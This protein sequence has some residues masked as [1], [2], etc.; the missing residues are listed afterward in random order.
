[1]VFFWQFPINFV[2]LQLVSKPKAFMKEHYE[3]QTDLRLQEEIKAR[4]IVEAKLRT[5]MNLN[6]EVRTP[7]SLIISSLVS[8]LKEDEDPHRRS[9][10]ETMRRNTERLLKLVH[11]IL[12]IGKAEQ[13]MMQMHMCET[14]L[15][16]FFDD[17][18][19]LFAQLSKAKMIIFNFEHDMQLL[20]VWIDRNHFDKAIVNI[21]T[22]AFKFTPVG[23][24]ITLRVERD[25]KHVYIY[26]RDTGIGIPE[27][28]LPHI[29]YRFYQALLTVDERNI[30]TGIGLDLTHLLVDLHHGHIEVHNN[31]DGPGCEFK[32]TLPLGC[33]HLTPQEMLLEKE[34][35]T[36]FNR[37]LEDELPNMHIPTDLRERSRQ[38][39]V[40]V[41]SEAD[42]SDFL[43]S[44]LQDDYEVTLCTTGGDGLAM[45]SALLPDLVITDMRIP[46][47][48]GRSLCARLKASSIT[49]HIP[50]ILLTSSNENGEYDRLEGVEADADAYVARPFDM[51][52]LRR[53]IVN[54]LHRYRML[55]LKYSRT[56]RLEELIDEVKM[57]SPDEKL[58]ERIM[59]VINNNLSNSDLCVDM[60]AD[61]AGISR[62]HLNRKM[63]E[64]TGQTPYDYIRSIRLKRAA[65]LLAE[66][67]ANV[68][69]V[70]Y[71]CGFS[72][73]ASFST[74]FKKAYGMSPREYMEHQS[75]Q[76]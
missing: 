55:K 4:E 61:E 65:Q 27:E 39:I 19:Q 47:M 52:V 18:H 31:S 56:D 70:M 6:H 67:D 57:K 29:F 5:Y 66:G 34:N 48:D 58:L 1:M 50:V 68:S 9:I 11:Q 30:G 33:D 7:L 46:D 26:V 41:E 23:G 43:I 54:L 37:L 73:A 60:I 32:I 71:A 2:P 72:N 45:V 75:R 20:P 74:V 64:L 3:S 53:I 21:I 25:E 17:I 28:K 14:D 69:E 12:D 42:V 63:K 51:D 49:G 62:V 15:I 24:T 35:V 36:H 44:E 38:Q 59:S 13:G 8:L 76:S 40:V 22:N 16:G 10:Y